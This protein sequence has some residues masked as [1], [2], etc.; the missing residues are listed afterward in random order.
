MLRITLLISIGVVLNIHTSQCIP[1]TTPTEERSTL[2]TTIEL[3]D[4]THHHSIKTEH[5]IGIALTVV[6]LV[7]LCVAICFMRKWRG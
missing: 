3:K 6:M 7:I 4:N 1:T 2:S 5:K